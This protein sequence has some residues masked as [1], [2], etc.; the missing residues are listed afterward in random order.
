M[1]ISYA[2]L[3]FVLWWLCLFIVLP[4]GARNQED[5]GEVVRGT[6]PGAPVLFR[7]WPKLA[8]DLDSGGGASGAG[9]MGAVEPL[10]AAL[11]ANSTRASASST[12][13]TD[14][15]LRGTATSVA[16]GV[17]CIASSKKKSRAVRPCM[18]S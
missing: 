14:A 12:S 8:G 4:F 16:D 5:A 17:S 9:G 13:V 3:Y 18:I 11:L 10:C 15:M 2:A 7:L 6:E 1:W